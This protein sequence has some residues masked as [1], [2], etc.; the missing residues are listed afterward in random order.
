MKTKKTI[1][2]FIILIFIFACASNKKFVEPC[3]EYENDSKNTIYLLM[4]LNPGETFKNSS[5]EIFKVL[6]SPKDFL[7]FSEQ[8][9]IDFMIETASVS[10]GSK[11]DSLNK[12]QKDLET[13]QDKRKDVENKK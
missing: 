8:L 13:E 6:K 11:L 4:P 1:Y 10:I 3:G 5:G 12:L 9:K 7:Q 2:C